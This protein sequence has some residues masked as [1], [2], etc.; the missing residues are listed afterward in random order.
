MS[1]YRCDC[2]D[3][4]KDNDYDNVTIVKDMWLCEMCDTYYRAKRR[5]DNIYLCD[6]CNYK[7]PIKE[8]K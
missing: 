4:Q 3:E 1:I 7:Y 2:C 5:K 6:V 8:S